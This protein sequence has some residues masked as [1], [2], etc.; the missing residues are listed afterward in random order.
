MKPFTQIKSVAA[1][2]PEANIDTDIIFPAR[3]LLL[4]EKAG[5][6]RYAFYEK[7]FDETSVPR[8]DF[9]LNTKPFSDSRILITGE[10]F[11]CGSS[12][13]QAVWTLADL[14]IK[15]I[16]APSFGE[17]FYANCFKSGILPIKLGNAIVDSLH[18][19]AQQEELFTVDLADKTISGLD[20]PPL[21]YEIAHYRREMLLSGDDEI[22]LI[23]NN[24]GEAINS[25]ERIQRINNPWLYESK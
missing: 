4:I 3:F 11:G 14:G 16:I 7:R 23:Q 20:A 6:G 5:I 12:R 15:C 8:P 19:R 24:D 13:E 21:H 1:S 18:F 2:L 10:N 25:F 22:S 17:I 9:I